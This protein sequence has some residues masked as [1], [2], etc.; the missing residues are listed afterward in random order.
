[1]DRISIAM[2]TYNGGKYLRHQLDS[3]LSQSIPP[4]EVIVCDDHSTD[5]TLDILREYSGQYP[6]KYFVNETRLGVIENF[7][8]AILLCQGEYIALADQDDVWNP[9]KLELSL[10]IMKR[11]ESSNTPCL[12][13]SDLEIVNSN[14]KTTDP[15]LWD[16]LKVNPL[17]ENFYT[18][19]FGNIVT[20]CTILVNRNFLK[21]VKEM[22]GDVPMHDSWMGLV[23][24]GLG[25]AGI[26]N[27]TTMKF[28]RH[29][30]NVTDAKSITTWQR[31]TRFFKLVAVEFKKSEFLTKELAQAKKFRDLYGNL[32][33]LEKRNALDRFILLENRSYVK[34][35][36]GS[37]YAKRFPYFKSRISNV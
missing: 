23:A 36:A 34:R 29:G 32:L 37:V 8:R 16:N 35:K 21:Y 3:I 18:L 2:A 25:R 30:Q 24:Y 6:L 4:F 13:Y 27:K 22:P 11:I 7:K 20:G 1:M 19:L 15:S 12:T 28:R 31:M 26:V 10:D 14:L 5:N 9:N 33:S 17:K